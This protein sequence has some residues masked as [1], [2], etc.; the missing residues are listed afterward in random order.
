M[1]LLF[2]LRLCSVLAVAIVIAHPPVP[3]A[4]QATV[5]APPIGGDCTGALPRQEVRELTPDQWQHLITAIRTLQAR[6]T[7]E[8]ASAYDRLSEIH[9]RFA[10]A[11]SIH[12]TAAFLPWHRLFLRAY[13]YELQQID[14]TVTV[15]YWDWTRDSQRLA[16]APF[17]NRSL[18]GTNGFGVNGAI[19][20][21]AFADWIPFRGPVAG[22]KGRDY[23][24]T[25]QW[26]NDI[27]LETAAAA[28][29][30]ARVLSRA[31]SYDALRTGIEIGGHGDVHIAIGGDMADFFS[32]NDPVFYL[33]H[34]FI[35]KLWA[36]WQAMPGHDPLSYGGPT[37]RG[38]NR[39]KLAD[40][41]PGFPGVKVRDVMRSSNLCVAYQQSTTP[42]K[43]VTTLRASASTV[44]PDDKV[45]Y[46]ATM[47]SALKG[48]VDFERSFGD[49]P[50][51]SLCTNVKPVFAVN[52]WTAACTVNA[53]RLRGGAAVKTIEADYKGGAGELASTGTTKLRIDPKNPTVLWTPDVT[54]EYGTPLGANL[55]AFESVRGSKRFSVLAA[56]GPE[57]SVQPG[58]V[59]EAGY[60]VLRLH[61]TPR[62]GPPQ[63][64]TRRVVVTPGTLTVIPRNLQ[65]TTGMATPKLEFS[66]TGFVAGQT[67]ASLT[68]FEEPICRVSRPE[69]LAEDAPLP[70]GNYPIFC[71]GGSSLNYRFDTSITGVL[72]VVSS[73]NL[74]PP[75][76]ELPPL[77]A[78]P[79]RQ[80][81]KPCTFDRGNR[82][83]CGGIKRRRSVERV[84]FVRNQKVLARARAVRRGDLLELR[85]R[86]KVKPGLYLLTI[87]QRSGKRR[88]VLVRV[89]RETVA[90][91]ASVGPSANSFVCRLGK[92]R[93]LGTRVR[94]G[95]RVT[96]WHIVQ[97]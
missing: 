65:I 30:V 10:N 47:S 73:D 13:E 33:H 41:L 15:P 88:E 54:F 64:L 28:P 76:Q 22:V 91:R 72:Q 87:V 31:K 61:F 68:G 81:P 71:E 27:G 4:G 63:L 77:G 45:T 95:V 23:G 34:A 29:A 90:Q 38:S 79:D 94:N 83:L 55:E 52:T 97:R 26:G 84:L 25:R 93:R 67:P 9:N 5:P 20:D 32:P 21:G 44:R 40:E 82:L 48:T 59:L 46:I 62:K 58:T 69:D 16:N 86:P 35:D 6:A 42:V 70:Q 56:P 74:E 78:G 19:R 12:Q 3:A 75:A 2:A 36:D 51:T 85:V 49:G 50:G 57:R 66:I 14:P 37:V 17:W 8:T 89:V 39:A 60:Q 92:A 18:L 43:T 11:G 7:P 96:S 24:L 1:P 80:R 53:K